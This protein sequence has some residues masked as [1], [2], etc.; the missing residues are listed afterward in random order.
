MAASRSHSQLASARRA[1]CSLQ[2]RSCARQETQ[3]CSEVRERSVSSKGLRAVLVDVGISR[4]HQGPMRRL[5][6]KQLT[7]HTEN[8][9]RTERAQGAKAEHRPQCRHIATERA[10]AHYTSSI[11]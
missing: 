10:C 4:Q 1:C 2:P 11:Q 7:T 6:A 3:A 5:R 8:T 9:R